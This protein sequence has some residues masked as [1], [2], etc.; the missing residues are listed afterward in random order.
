MADGTVGVA[1][2]GT[3]DRLID[4]EVL[5]IGGQDVYR[6][7]VKAYAQEEV[8]TPAGFQQITTGASASALTV[9]GGATYALVQADAAIRYRDDGTNPT[10]TVG[11]LISAAG[12]LFY[13]GSLAA[14]RL[15]GVVVGA[16]VN[17]AYYGAS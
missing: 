5:V 9:P 4:N 15:I 10:A 2:A 11:I 13:T 16:T 14:F 7:R 12:V 1:Q 6:Q 17:I 8:L 3:P